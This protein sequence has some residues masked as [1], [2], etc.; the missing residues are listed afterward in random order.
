MCN[1]TYQRL[2]LC[3]CTYQRLIVC[4]C[5]YRRLVVLCA[6][7]HI[8]DL[9]CATAHMKDL[10]CPT[11]HMEDDICYVHMILVVCTCVKDDICYVQLHIWKMKEL[12]TL[13][14]GFRDMVLI[15]DFWGLHCHPQTLIGGLQ[16]ANQTTRQHRQCK[17]RG[18]ITIEI[19]TEY[20]R[21]DVEHQD[22]YSQ[23]I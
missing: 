4:S 16:S 23:S 22:A 19:E 20:R 2:I 13:L 3:N 12:S 6:T 1:C 7:V 14:W 10:L 11:V 9:L 21:H 18:C 17:V 5:T 15:A 8:K